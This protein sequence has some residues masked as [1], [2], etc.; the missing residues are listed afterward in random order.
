MSSKRKAGEAGSGSAASKIVRQAEVAAEDSK[1]G[2]NKGKPVLELLVVALA[3]L[4]L[5]T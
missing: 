4:V 5:S 2:G 1:K 3:Q